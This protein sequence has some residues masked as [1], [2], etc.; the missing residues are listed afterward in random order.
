[1]INERVAAVEVSESFMTDR[2]CCCAPHLR[3]THL[4]TVPLS[5]APLVRFCLL[6]PLWASPLV[7]S[8]PLVVVCPCHF[9]VC[10]GWDAARA[11][12]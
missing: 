5:L 3:V 8:C 9:R 10:V 11:S 1:M 7:S 2:R 4:T 12:A 6:F